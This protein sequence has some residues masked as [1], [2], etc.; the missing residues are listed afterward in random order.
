MILGYDRRFIKPTKNPFV[1]SACKSILPWLLRQQGLEIRSTVNSLSILRRIGNQPTVLIP[2]HSDR[3]DPLVMFALTQMIGEDFFYVAARET[4]DEDWGIRGWLFQQV[5]A[6]SVLRGFHDL[7][8]VRAT[9]SL[10]LRHERKVVLFAEGEVS[11][12]HD[13]IQP[14]KKDGLTCIMAAQRKL[15]AQSSAASVR[16]VPVAISYE[17]QDAHHMELLDEATRR[18]EACLNLSERHGDLQSRIDDICRVMMTNL[19]K[20]YG[21]S[22]DDSLPFSLRVDRLSAHFSALLGQ[23]VGAEI[24]L[25][26]GATSRLHAVSAQMRR[27]SWSQKVKSPYGNRLLMQAHR[28]SQSATQDFERIQRLHVMANSLQAASTPEMLWGIIDCLEQEI[29]GSVLWKGRRTAWVDVGE[30]IRVLD[31]WQPYKID[32]NKALDDLGSAIAFSIEQR[33]QRPHQLLIQQGP[34][35][36][37]G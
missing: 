11:G 7:M 27:P 8:Y 15:L 33:L 12:R 9:I 30:P 13:C 22:P 18:I 34:L 2:N 19:E 5:G 4:F 14:L 35:V 31:Y 29:R 20:Y 6:Y 37:A 16:I 23:L 17:L 24:Q 25:Q 1:V 10:I 28:R 36:S 32:K 26:T 21:L 3:F